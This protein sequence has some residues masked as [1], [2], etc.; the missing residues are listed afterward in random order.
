[1]VWDTDWRKDFPI[2][3]IDDQ[4]EESNADGRATRAILDRLEN[5]GFSSVKAS[6]VTDGQLEFASQ[7]SLSCVVVDWDMGRRN[8]SIT[9]NRLIDIVREKNDKIPIFV[10]TDKMTVKDIP[11]DAAKKINGYVWK[12]EDTPQ[13]IS[14]RIEQAVEEYLENMLPPFFKELVKYVDKY[15]YAWHTPGH[16]GGEAFLKT[17][18][19][20]M[21][22]DFYGE[23]TLRGDLSVSVPEL[24]SLLDQVGVIND[25]E[26]SAAKNFGADKTYFITNGTSTANHVVFHGNIARGDVVLVD[27]N[28]HKSIMQG[29][30]MTG[31]Y[32]VYLLPTRNDY[33]IIGPIHASEFDRATIEKKLKESPFS[34]EIKGKPVKMAVVTNST[35]DGLCY[36]VDIIKSKLGSEVEKL[37]FDEA[38]FA[39]AKFHPIYAHRFGMSLN[40]D[41]G[42]HHPAIFATQSTHKL[43]AAFSQGSMIHIKDEDNKM[44]YDRFKEAFMLHTSTSPQYSII[45]S[46]D[47]G[48]KMM[49]GKEGKALI[50]DTVEEA[51]V[52]RKKMDN[53]D[54]QIAKEEN[55][56]RK[57]FFKVWQPEQ[58]TV[59]RGNPTAI[60]DTDLERVSDDAL[61]RYPECWDLAPNAKWHGFPGLE[62][63]Y[64]MLDPTKVTIITPGIKDDGSMDDWGIPAHVVAE[65]L[66]QKGIVVEKTGHYSFL[67]L[68]SIGITKGKSGTM[69]SELLEL[70]RLYD[71]NAP[72][73]EVFPDSPGE[74]GDKYYNL[75]LQEF[76]RHMH[77]YLSKANVPD[78]VKEVYAT[79]PEA[80]MIP[81]EAFDKIASDEVQEIGLDSIKGRTAATMVIPYPPGIPVIMPGEKFSAKVQKTIDFLKLG[82]EFDNIY[83]GFENEMQGVVKKRKGNKLKYYIMCVRKAA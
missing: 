66:D 53:L 52:F 83:P 65:F 27:R 10:L 78:L 38:W 67:V 24:G 56:N 80:S 82:Q 25:A 47:V 62:D 74:F 81:A 64:I 1:M 15:K 31:A 22:Y 34:K 11:L 36:N 59:E 54:E 12:L 40:G 32:P 76:C 29:I 8:G 7:S 58:V 6:S 55:K 43:L 70:K 49:E 19:G 41:S 60:I 30:I 37:H 45:A 5:K 46:L 39:Y 33:G 57:W 16:S 75:G 72:L 23:N 71:E 35:Y 17:P 48:S 21:F 3:V 42:D 79:L 20:K 68:F 63:K 61:R 2:L 26:N 9:P 28:C 18:A 4:I 77:D 13:F 50:D 14:G 44:D 73:E 51:I 69:I